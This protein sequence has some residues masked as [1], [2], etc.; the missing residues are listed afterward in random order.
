MHTGQNVKNSS[1]YILG[2]RPSWNGLI[3]DPCIPAKWKEFR[4]EREFRGCRYNIFIKNENGVSM[5]VKSVM[6]NG[7]PV[8]GNIIPYKKGRNSAN[9]TVYM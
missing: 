2:I 4:V 3:V 9:V 5:G 7:A 6:V 1:Q 8:E